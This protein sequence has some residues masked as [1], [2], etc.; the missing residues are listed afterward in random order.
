MNIIKKFG[1]KLPIFQAPL[2]GYPNQAKLVAE[3]SNNGA[4]G[5][6]SANYQT[7]EEIENN[8]KQINEM[9]D[10]PFA[11]LFDVRSGDDNLELTE[12]AQASQYLDA[13]YKDLKVDASDEIPLPSKT[14]II[15]QLLKA[16][17]AAVIFQNGL[18]SD[19]V[20]EQFK[21]ADIVTMAIA[22]NSLEVVVADKLVDCIILQG[23]EAAGVQSQFNNDLNIDRYPVNTLLLHAL[24][25]TE[26]P[27]ITWGEYQYP[28]NIVGALINGASSVIIDT[29]FWTT[30]ESPAPN[31][32]RKALAEHNEMLTTETAVWTGYS[33]L[34]LQNKLTKLAKIQDKL[35]PPQKQQRLLQPIIRAAIAQDNTDYLP[36]WAGYFS[37]TTK[38]T[39]AELCEKYQR[40]LD[41]IMD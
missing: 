4:L 32:Y 1:L 36:L 40:K 25:I 13:A 16:K 6:Y 41:D 24:D 19:A 12:R 8:L 39:V 9:T 34:C 33:S 2:E 28:Q 37:V 14:K 18:P 7:L 21:D 30:Q 3:T 23:Q 31:G 38:K 35:L 10:S 17:P 15:G 26:K 11:V 5:I 29:V 22:S 20:I 27:L